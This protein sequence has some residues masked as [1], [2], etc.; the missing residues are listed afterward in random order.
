MLSTREKNK[1]KR[2]EFKTP[3][4]PTG[5]RSKNVF[6]HKVFRHIRTKSLHPFNFCQEITNCME[7]EQWGS[8][9]RQL[10]GR[11]FIYLC[12]KAVRSGQN[13]IYEYSPLQLSTLATPL[14]ESVLLCVRFNVYCL[15]LT[16]AYTHV[17]GT[18]HWKAA[19][20]SVF[21]FCLFS[22]HIYTHKDFHQLYV[23]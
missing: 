22:T 12:S 23:Y 21:Q 18:W 17:E 8:Q 20:G 19:L 7:G 5:R 2:G 14:E 9:S 15:I 3:P 4:Y 1:Q 6:V 16:L 13:T 11:I 10:E